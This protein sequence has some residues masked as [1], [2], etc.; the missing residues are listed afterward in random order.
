MP[1]NK[2]PQKVDELRRLAEE[3]LRELDGRPPPPE[4]EDDQLRLVH[5]LQVHQIEL[6][7]Q[8]AELRQTKNDLEI[9]LEEYT[10]LYD[11]S[12]VGY[13]AL[14]RSGKILGANLTCTRFLEV[15][16][17]GLIG[18][19]F[20]N[21]VAVED[22]ADFCAFLENVYSHPNKD[23]CELALRQKDNALFF[24][25]I[26]AQPAPSGQECRMA[27]IDVNE[28][29]HAEQA[30]LRNAKLESIGILA[31]GLAH[32]FNNIL[33]AILGNI[34]LAKSQIHDPGRLSIRLE[35]AEKAAI[36]A[37]DLT[38]QLV[39]FARGGEPIKKII[40]IEQL[41]RDAVNFSL[42][43]SSVQCEFVLDESLFPVNADEGQLHQVFHNLVLNAVQSMAENG[44]IV[45]SAK[46]VV[47]S[48]QEKSFVQIS[49]A[50]SGPGLPEEV[51]PKIF[52][53]YF[54]TKLKGSGLG[55]SICFSIIKR[56]RGNISVESS[57]GQGTTFHIT[58]PATKP[59][60]L[61]EPAPADA[62]HYGEGRILLMDDEETVRS[63]AQ[64]SLEELGYQAEVTADGSAAI[65]LYRQRKAEG[66]PFDAVILDLTVPGGMGGKEA[67]AM[68]QQIEPE[69]KAIVSS[70]YSSDPVMAE[71]QHYGFSALLRKPYRLEELSKVLADLLIR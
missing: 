52:D 6:E 58:L 13:L 56:H 31:G 18:R 49:I 35:N 36:R 16:R 55:L 8:N 11:C 39:T 9:L 33:A 25:Q 60:V 17:A 41:L 57:L 29:M 70:G 66:S 59:G 28:R 44:K 71:Y 38:L 54:S 69:V 10:N 2:E 27:M 21:F 26:E 24:V 48:P 64:A 40:H 61:P 42:L 30:S 68:L 22:R 53:P 65:E 1:K 50:D 3:K 14:D 32:D 20:K 19:Q 15:E 47:S 45:V 51:L 63:I 43:G 34:S 37:K 67:I 5:E 23:A 7:M 46:N 62:L 4:R 12:P